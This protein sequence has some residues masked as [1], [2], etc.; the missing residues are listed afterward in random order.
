MTMLLLNIDVSDPLERLMWSG[1]SLIR[2]AAGT[3]LTTNDNAH[4]TSL[5]DEFAMLVAP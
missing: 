2:I 1:G 3:Y 4:D 5:A